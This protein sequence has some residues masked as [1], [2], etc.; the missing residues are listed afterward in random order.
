MK[1]KIVVAKMM[2]M[3]SMIFHKQAIGHLQLQRRKEYSRSGQ[4]MDS[5]DHF[6]FYPN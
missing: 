4:T 6:V 3:I 1:N 2:L 5:A